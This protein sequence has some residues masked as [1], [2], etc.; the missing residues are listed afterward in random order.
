MAW[1]TQGK[2][3][4][5]VA[6]LPHLV[7]SPFILQQVSLKMFRLVL[8]RSRFFH[9][10]CFQGSVHHPCSFCLGPYNQPIT[11]VAYLSH[12]GKYNWPSV[13]LSQHWAN[14][15]QY[16]PCAWLV[17]GYLRNLPLHTHAP[18]TVHTNL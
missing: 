2:I 18:V 11:N 12:S 8:C 17:G 14:N 1:N 3:T 7:I 16:S 13:N 10:D 9:M 4:L 15:F 5:Q 6:L